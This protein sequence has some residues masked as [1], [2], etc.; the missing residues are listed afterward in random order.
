MQTT[1]NYELKV[2]EGTDKFNPITVEN[3]NTEEIDGILKDIEITG[4]TIATEVKAGNTHAL[5]RSNPDCNMFR[6]LATSKYL[7]GEVF[8]LDT[9]QVTALLTNGSTLGDGA[10]DIGADVLGI[11]HDTR[12]TLFVVS[13]DIATAR[14]SERLGGELPSYYG[15]AGDVATALNTAN[16]AGLLANNLATVIGTPVDTQT[17]AV[18]G[19]SVTFTSGSINATSRVQVCE[20]T[21]AGVAITP[22]SYKTITVNN[23][24]VVL[25]FDTATEAHILAL[26]VAN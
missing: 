16:A 1:D 19:T 2:Y 23:G 21:T 6:F 4:V 8:T 14:D 25:T 18:G 11:I 7:A 12:L 13:G 24:S 17:L 5:T 10:Y 20:V 26:F 22:I 3:Y 9:I 15:T